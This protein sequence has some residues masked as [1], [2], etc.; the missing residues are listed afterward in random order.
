MDLK[1]LKQEW[2]KLEPEKKALIGLGII[3]FVIVI[4][5][6]NPF[7][8]DPNMR[9]VQGQPT[10][11][12]PVTSAPPVTTSNNSTNNTTLNNGTFQI[13]AEVAKNI[14]TG[15]NPGFTA[16]NPTQG[17]VT[18]NSTVFYVW[19]VPMT[20]GSISKNVYV[21]LSTGMIVKTT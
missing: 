16:G 21:D 13:A 6:L 3:V 8:S 20:Q 12:Q 10:D 14:A 1:D 11:V 17:N 19:I 2:D 9:V 4:Y 15:A 5:A 18:V 7:H